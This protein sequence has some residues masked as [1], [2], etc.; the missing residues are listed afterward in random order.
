[1]LSKG[2]TP[3]PAELSE[4]V[5]RVLRTLSGDPSLP[6][7]QT[8]S[9]GH[10]LDTHGKIENFQSRLK[11]LISNWNFQ[12]R[13]KIPILTFRISRKN[14]G[15]AGGSLEN[16][17]LDW[18]FQSRRAILNFFNLW[19]SRDESQKRSLHPRTLQN[20][21]FGAPKFWG[22]SPKL[23]AALRGI[24]PYLCTPV[25]PRG[26]IKK[27]S[28]EQVF[29]NKVCRLPDSCEREEGK[30]SRELFEKVR[31]NAVFFLVFLD[32]D[33]FLGNFQRKRHININNFV[34]WLPRWG[35]GSP[36][37]VARGQIFMCC[38]R[39]PRNINMF[40]VRVPG[41]EHQCDRVTE[42]LF[43]CQM[44]MC[45]FWMCLF[46]PLT[47]PPPHQNQ[48]WLSFA[49]LSLQVLLFIAFF[50]GCPRGG[51]NFTSLSRCS[52]PFLQSAKST[53]SH[54]KSCN[55]VGGTPSSTPWVVHKTLHIENYCVNNSCQ[56]TITVTENIF[57]RN[58]FCMCLCFPMVQKASN[59]IT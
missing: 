39:N 55:F 33:G 13:L 42:K 24:H 53:L 29:L 25:L 58:H 44:F 8:S 36:D 47:P 35:G 49:M 19:T 18:K 40:V 6:I 3:C 31:V 54:L 48:A 14:R 50:R 15:L 32:L 12:S 51:N 5:N 52:R 11:F 26:Q 2:G 16:F 28:S 4:R 23:F 1:M 37:R 46:W 17:N 7:L 9:A 57:E 38:V 10:C 45:L 34:R 30:S 27:R 43:M 21:R 56:V 59:T 41:R 20:K 22:I